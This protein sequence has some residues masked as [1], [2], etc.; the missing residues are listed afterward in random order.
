MIYFPLSALFNTLA[1]VFMGFFVLFKAPKSKLKNNLLLLCI[2]AT[3]WALFYFLWQIENNGQ[4]ALVWTKILMIGAVWGPFV[5]YRIV[6]IFFGWETKTKNKIITAAAFFFSAIFTILLTTPLMVKNV[7]PIAGFKFWPKAGL[8]YTPFLIFFIGFSLYSL[9]LIFRGIKKTESLLK[10]SQAKFMLFG[11]IITYATASTN[12]FLWYDIPIKPY[13]NI[14]ASLYVLTTVYAIVKHRLMD[15][16]LIAQQSAVFI[17]SLSTILAI[18]IL[19]LFIT[20]EIYH[21]NS[22][23]VHAIIITCTVSGFP[24]LK[25]YFD[26][27]ANKYFFTSLPDATR[28]TN[29]LNEKL[30]ST[31]NTQEIYECILN[32]F[33]TSFHPQ[34]INILIYD[35]NKTNYTVRHTTGTRINQNKIDEYQTFFNTLKNSNDILVSEELKNELI[36]TIEKEKIAESLTDLEIE[37]LIPLNIKGETFGLITLDKKQSKDI[38][39]SNDLKTIETIRTNI[40]FA[41]NNAL[42]YQKTANINNQP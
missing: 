7:E 5:L 1:Y 16:K 11:I 2:T 35:K 19:F 22:F 9:F 23:I 12:Y 33:S 28:L 21:T 13:G 29:L 25:R 30:R 42:L 41:V 18:A 40:A 31:L 14:F 20:K 34:G 24:W 32:V 27:L 26:N 6:N 8:L 38:Y 37:I 10:K 17:A 15:I 39:N 4:K 3:A 36:T